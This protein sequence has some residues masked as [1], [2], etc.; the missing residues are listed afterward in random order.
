MLAAS[1]GKLG[2]DDGNA[3]ALVMVRMLISANPA[4][5]RRW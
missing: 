4:D 5:R 1:C 3:E 2:E